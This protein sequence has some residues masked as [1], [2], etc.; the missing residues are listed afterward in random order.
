MS[1][2]TAWIMAVKTITLSGL[3]RDPLTLLMAPPESETPEE[4]SRRMQQEEQ[5]KY[6]SS[7]IDEELNR[8]RKA[9]KPVK[10]LLLGKVLNVHT[11]DD[12]AENSAFCVKGQSE[13]GMSLLRHSDTMVSNK[14]SRK[15]YDAKK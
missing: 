4:R 10:I 1:S 6:I 12:D 2:V 11:I 3:S 7:V 13:S 8:E 14:R 5:A 15:I 9:P